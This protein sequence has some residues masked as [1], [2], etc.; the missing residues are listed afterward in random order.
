MRYF[1]TYF[2]R[3]YFLRGLA[4]YHSLQEHAG[5]FTLWVLCFDEWSHDVLAKLALP[6]LRPIALA[7]FERGDDALLA[8]KPTRSRVEYYFTCTP[9]LPLYVLKHHPD[10]DIITYLDADLFFYADPQPIF[11]E[12][13]DGSILI[14]EHRFPPD[15]KSMEINGLYNVGLLSFRN[16]ARGRECLEWWR[17]RCLEW[18]YDRAEDG[19]YGDQKYLDDWPER[20]PGVV[21]LQH[22]GA[23]LAPWNWRSYAVTAGNDGSVRV[24]G[25][26]LI[27]FHYAS[28]KMLAS[29]LYDPVSEGRLYGEMPFA[30]R[31]RLYGP[32]MEAL[33][34][35]ARRL[36]EQGVAGPFFHYSDLRHGG[37]GWRKFV[38]KTLRRTLM[39]HLGLK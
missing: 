7:D 24:D 2:D 23:G 3:H 18:C 1:C 22:P 37:Y 28:L 12:L 34:Q 9:S 27:F 13:G 21:V 39:I 6:D 10:I 14:S 16:D 4:L 38:S 20:F 36:R 15:L 32:Y 8:V 30:L 33:K 11:D 17:S 29:W 31:R 5:P 25:Q 26:P 35:T 19:K